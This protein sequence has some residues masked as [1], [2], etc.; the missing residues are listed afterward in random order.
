[1]SGQ[2]AIVGSGILGVRVVLK[3]TDEIGPVSCEIQVGFLP[4]QGA[5]IDGVGPR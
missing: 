4:F 3:D 1:V 2:Y 5:G